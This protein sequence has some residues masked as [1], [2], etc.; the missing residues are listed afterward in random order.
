M[1][2]PDLLAPRVRGARPFEAFAAH[3]R[4]APKK[5]LFVMMSGRKSQAVVDA[6][7]RRVGFERHD[8]ILFVYDDSIW[9]GFDWFPKVVVVYARQQLKFWYYKRFVLPWHAESYRYVHFVDSDC[10]FTTSTPMFNASAYEDLLE[11]H[12]IA[13][14]QPAQIGRTVYP[15]L[16]HEHGH[17]H[18][19]WRVKI[20]EIGYACAPPAVAAVRAG[21]FTEHRG[22]RDVNPGRPMFTVASW[23]YN[24]FWHLHQEALPTGYG[25]DYVWCKGL[26][27]ML[28]MPPNSACAVVNRYP[29]THVDLHESSGIK[30]NG[31]SIPS[32]MQ[33]EITFF[34]DHCYPHW[35]LN[36]DLK[37]SGF[38][39]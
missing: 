23:A 2:H 35:M 9:S 12:H 29:I 18:A 39:D 33:S 17:A 7:I 27:S 5:S 28:S 36:W 8:F 15:E 16:R 3:A 14:A 25:L 37:V 38:L 26:E 11:R 24:A 1:L 21:P 34:R 31:Q 30:I 6:N 19:A 20:V 10:G 4:T 32:Y 22:R 13:L